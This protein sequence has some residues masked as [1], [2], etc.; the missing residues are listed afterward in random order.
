[1]AGEWVEDE[2]TAAP[3]DLSFGTHG[4]QGADPSSFTALAGDLDREIRHCGQ[5]GR[6]RV[7]VAQ[8]DLVED[9]LERGQGSRHGTG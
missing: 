5:R 6:R 9:D 1:M 7:R 3:K 4:E 2:A 8:V